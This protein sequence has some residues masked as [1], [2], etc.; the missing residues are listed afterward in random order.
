M[1]KREWWSITLFLIETPN[2]WPCVRSLYAIALF[3][4]CVVGKLVQYVNHSKGSK[5]WFGL[6][7]LY[8]IHPIRTEKNHPNLLH[9]SKSYNDGLVGFTGN[10]I[11]VVGSKRPN[12]EYIYDL[13]LWLCGLCTK[14]RI[15]VWASFLYGLPT[16]RTLGQ[17]RQACCIMLDS[18]PL[19]HK[20]NLFTTIFLEKE[21]DLSL[22][23]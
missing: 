7:K 20:F 18:M 14:T 19:W 16:C 15:W 11:S 2:C 10:G 6:Q 3:I 1:M 4:S 17:R 12:Y 21:L 22:D 5:L 23:V 9:T 13:F 8:F